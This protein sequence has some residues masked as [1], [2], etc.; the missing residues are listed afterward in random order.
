MRKVIS[1]LLSIFIIFS[2]SACSFNK[3]R[4]EEVI[5]KEILYREGENENI[6]RENIYSKQP[7]VRVEELPIEIEILAPDSIGIRYLEAVY[8]ND[9]QY[10]I[11]G[12]SITVLLKDKNEKTYLAIYEEV[13]PGTVSPMFETFAP[14]S[15]KLEDCEFMVYEITVA[16]E[17]GN[18]IHI[19]Y[20]IDKQEYNWF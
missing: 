19:I 12:L 4:N 11:K 6:N 20:D 3:A 9:S 15:G 2:L 8:K 1:L 10:T 16:K 18:I 17:D 7:L 5:P 13:L 14:E